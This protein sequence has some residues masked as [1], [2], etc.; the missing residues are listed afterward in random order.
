MVAVPDFGFG[1]MEVSCVIDDKIKS[2][3]FRLLCF[4]VCASENRIGA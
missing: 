3:D 1:G 4:V 2:D